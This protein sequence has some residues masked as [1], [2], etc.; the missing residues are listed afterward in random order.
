MRDFTARLEGMLSAGALRSICMDYQGRWGIFTGREFIAIFRRTDSI[1][2]A[3]RQ[4]SGKPAG[5]SVAK[6]VW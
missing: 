2:V 5:D 4:R 6:R 3:W 1:A